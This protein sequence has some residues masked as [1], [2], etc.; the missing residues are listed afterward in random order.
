MGGDKQSRLGPWRQG[1][2]LGVHSI[3]GG[4]IKDMVKEGGVLGEN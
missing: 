2:A 4:N 3:V 1:N